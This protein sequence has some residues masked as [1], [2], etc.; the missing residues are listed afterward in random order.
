MLFPTGTHVNSFLSKIISINEETQDY[1]RWMNENWKDRQMEHIQHFAP[2]F[3]NY[4]NNYNP[5]LNAAAA[6]YCHPG[7]M[8]P[9]ASDIA[10]LIPIAAP[11]LQQNPKNGGVVLSQTAV[12]A[13]ANRFRFKSFCFE[14]VRFCS[15]SACN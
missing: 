8:L 10:A 9:N 6:A 3:T 4:D 2:Y 15:G 1:R 13:S 7:N 5:Y 12:T 11:G 14:L